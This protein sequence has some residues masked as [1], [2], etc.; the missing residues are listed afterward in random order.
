M[1]NTEEMQKRPNNPSYNMLFAYFK[2]QGYADELAAC[3]ARKMMM[4]PNAANSKSLIASTPTIGMSINHAG[5]SS[6]GS[7]Y[8]RA[9]LL[10]GVKIRPR[11]I[12]NAWKM[13]VST[14]PVGTHKAMAR[15]IIPITLKNASKQKEDGMMDDMNRTH[16]QRK[17]QSRSNHTISANN[18]QSNSGV[19]GSIPRQFSSGTDIDMVKENYP[20]QVRPPVDPSMPTMDDI[21]R[22]I[23]RLY[24][25]HSMGACSRAFR[26]KISEFVEGIVQ[27]HRA[28]TLTAKDLIIPSSDEI[29]AGCNTTPKASSNTTSNINEAQTANLYKYGASQ[30]TKNFASVRNNGVVTQIY[31][32]D[33]RVPEPPT[34][35][36]NNEFNK[37]LQ[38][39]ERFKNMPGTQSVCFVANLIND[40]QVY[41]F[42]PQKGVRVVG[43]CED[44]EKPY[45]RLT[46]EPNPATVRSEPVLKLAF[47]HVF[48]NFLKNSN[49]RYIEEQF[50][51]IRQD[52]QVQH[53]RSPFVIK[54]YAT[55]ARVALLHGDLDQF[56]QC[57]T[58]LCHLHR[59]LKGFKHYKMEFECYFLLYL[60]MQKMHMGVLRYL[61]K[62][63][64]VDVKNNVGAL[65]SEFKG[66]VYFRYANKIRRLLS[67]ENFVEY[68][69]LANTESI[70]A[71]NWLEEIYN[72]AFSM[73]DFS[74]GPSNLTALSHEVDEP[75]NNPPFFTPFLFR[76]FEPRFRMTAL[77]A[78]SNT[79]ISLATETIKDVLRFR[80]VDECRAF[81]SN[82]GGVFNANG[83]IDCKQSLP[84]FLSS[85][86][87]RSKKQ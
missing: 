66:S 51:S 53:L 20:S 19:L 25:H 14:T 30:P 24:A 6:S 80:S 87:L 36:A 72:E 50:R 15:N 22:W 41:N 85:P 43:T 3:E 63:L 75:I 86:L 29:M 33:S 23:Q 73:D 79:A 37:R 40:I 56:N 5:D 62:L 12:E 58:Q 84:N 65:N 4:Q 46:A 27:K 35:A 71:T 81:V 69:R 32:M 1:R 61:R 68:F 16:S 9:S 28:G 31:G 76:M 38:R 47:K 64:L 8:D 39:S 83:N 60:A 13:P 17:V 70:D 74:E 54:L 7:T 57:Q 52:I 26:T 42:K 82:N 10:R 44:L 67:E 78:M 48:D 45:L 49:Y 11:E 18:S 77:V 55:N 2:Q 34:F 59:Q 21:N